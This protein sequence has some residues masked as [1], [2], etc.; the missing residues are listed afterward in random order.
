M[1]PQHN[2]IH[3]HTHT[4]TYTPAC[5]VLVCNSRLVEIVIIS[6]TERDLEVS[7]GDGFSSAL[8]LKLTTTELPKYKNNQ[9]CFFP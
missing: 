5:P 1:Q 4:H 8:Q 6:Y 9:I 2:I 7:N 3:N